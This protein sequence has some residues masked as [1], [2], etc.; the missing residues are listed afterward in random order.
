[1][2]NLRA[3]FKCLLN[4]LHQVVFAA[5]PLHWSNQTMYYSS[6]ICIHRRFLSLDKM[7]R[8]MKP[9]PYEDRRKELGLFSL[10]KKAL[11]SN[12]VAVFQHLQGINKKEVDRVFSRVS[13]I[14]QEVGNGF[15][16]KEVRFRLQIEEELIYSEGGKI[17]AKVAQRG[18]CPI[19][20]RSVGWDSGQAS[21]AEHIPA[22]CRGVGLHDFSR[23]LPTQ[24]I[25]SF[26]NKEALYWWYWT[27]LGRW[28]P[29]I[30]GSDKKNCWIALSTKME[31]SSNSF[32]V[33]STCLM[34]C[35]SKR[36]RKNKFLIASKGST[37]EANDWLPDNVQVKK[38]TVTLKHAVIF[39]SQTET[40][41][42]SRMAGMR[43]SIVPAHQED[44]TLDAWPQGSHL[45]QVHMEVTWQKGVSESQTH[46]SV[47]KQGL[48]SLQ[49][50]HP[51]RDLLLSKRCRIRH[52][53]MA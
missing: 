46:Q 9:L 30:I 21:L 19:P 7:I 31:L 24:T 36:S 16:L 11:Q 18:G 4:S 17:L 38:E 37:F 26:C 12:L 39:N 35:V 25:L 49:L 14:E 45:T 10:E 47:L 48:L 29:R 2:R 23:T 34:P 22:H 41:W 15:K 42:E 5:E 8:G 20:G 13:S 52:K 1:M 44:M 27:L 43:Q 33:S 53:K 51:A 3:E 50:C 28:R 40:T 6:C 32:H